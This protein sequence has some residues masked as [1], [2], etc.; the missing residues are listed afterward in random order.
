MAGGSARHFQSAD[1][2]GAQNPLTAKGVG[3]TF[4]PR[5]KALSPL[6]L[7]P[8]SPLRCSYCLFKGLPLSLSLSPPPS[9]SQPLLWL[10][11]AWETKLPQVR[12]LGVW[13]V[14]SFPSPSPTLPKLVASPP[15]PPPHRGGRGLGTN[16]IMPCADTAQGFGAVA[17]ARGGGG[18]LWWRESR[19]DW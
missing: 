2:K 16:S 9:L 8:S 11:A 17:A 12:F 1:G 10:R 6:A 18:G 15:P 7:V 4:F 19:V 14:P 13:S 3:A 5:R